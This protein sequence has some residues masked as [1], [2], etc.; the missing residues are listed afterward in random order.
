MDNAISRQY[1]YLPAVYPVLLPAAGTLSISIKEN[2][3]SAVN[4]RL[5]TDLPLVISGWL[6]VDRRSGTRII[7]LRFIASTDLANS[8]IDDAIAAVPRHYK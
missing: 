8:R 5:V 1:R 4:H 7:V 6:K 3:R 2:Y